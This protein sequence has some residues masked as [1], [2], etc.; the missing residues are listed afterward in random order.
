[1]TSTARSQVLRG[2]LNPMTR[3]SQ[4]R[5]GEKILVVED[6]YL[7]AELLCDF[8]REYG[9]EPIGPAGR[10][11]DG[12]RLARH[13]AIKGAILDMVYGEGRC[14]PIAGIL[15]ARKVPF[16]FLTGCHEKSLI[17]LEFCSAPVVRKPFEDNE[18]GAALDLI[19]GRPAALSPGRCNG[20]DGLRFGSVDQR[21]LREL[22]TSRWGEMPSLRA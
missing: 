2:S 21:S 17:S 20:S 3:P 4:V 8:L 15:K 1:M 5:H 10:M 13:G 11:Q 19:L 7:L 18:L 16:V 6:S 12:C 9:M 14:L 22:A